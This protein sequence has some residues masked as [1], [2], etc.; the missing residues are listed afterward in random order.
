MSLAISQRGNGNTLIEKRK[1]QQEQRM[2]GI[3]KFIA[4]AKIHA[5][6]TEKFVSQNPWLLK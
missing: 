4:D 2:K 3:V 1:A 5:P 6:N